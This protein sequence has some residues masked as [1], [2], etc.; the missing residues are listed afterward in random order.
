MAYSLERYI[1]T[2]TVD[3]VVNIDNRWGF[4]YGYQLFENGLLHLKNTTLGKFCNIKNKNNGG[5]CVWYI[6]KTKK[7]TLV[8]I[9]FVCRS[10]LFKDFYIE[11]NHQKY[12]L[13]AINSS[14]EISLDSDMPNSN[15]HISDNPNNVIYK[16]GR[17][18]AILNLYFPPLPEDAKVIDVISQKRSDKRSN[19]DLIWKGIQLRN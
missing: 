2:T 7:Y 17:W 13:K 12:P 5:G 1:G 18:Y 10:K 8:C 14:A 6:I 19:E 9:H 15:I 11:Y 3:G 16:T 4:A